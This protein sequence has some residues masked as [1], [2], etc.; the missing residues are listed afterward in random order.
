MRQLPREVARYSHVP[1]LD[2]SDLRPMGPPD[3]TID[4]ADTEEIIHAL[5]IPSA[6]EAVDELLVI[7]ASRLTG[8]ISLSMSSSV[9]IQTPVNVPM[10]SNPQR[11]MERVK[12]WGE[13]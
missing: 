1:W 2:D 3:T 11:H 13:Q 10:Q 6:V 5:R 9:A 12:D 8:V 4:R 7:R